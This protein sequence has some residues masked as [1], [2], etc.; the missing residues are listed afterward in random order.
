MK[1]GTK[2]IVIALVLL[3][4]ACGSSSSPTSSVTSAKSLPLLH[5][6]RGATPGIYDDQGRQVLLHGVNYGAL[7]DYYIDQPEYPAPVL[8]KASDFPQMAALG[9]NSVRLLLSWS[10]VEP[11]PGVYDET[12]LAQV[13][14]QI[15]KAAAQGLYV[16]VD[17]HQDA[18]GKF[19]A[20]RETSDV[21]LPPLLE[22]AIGWDGA[23]EWATITNGLTTCRIQQRELSPAVQAA[24][25]NFYLDTQGIQ[26]RFIAMWQHVV[27]AVAPYNNVVGYDL[28]NEPN[29]GFLV[30]ADAVTYLSV[31]YTRLITAIRATEAAQAKPVQHI[32]FFEPDIIWSLLGF[33]LPTLPIFTDDTN[34]VFSPHFYCGAGAPSTAAQCFSYAQS[35]SQLYQTTFWV[36]EWGY[37]G[38]PDTIGP[39]VYEFSAN[40][41]QMLVGAAEWQWAQACGDPHTIGKPGNKPGDTVVQLK[42]L[43]CPGDVDLGYVQANAMA[44]SR[45]YPRHAPGRLQQVSANIDSGELDMAGSGTGMLELWIPD[46]IGK[47]KISGNGLGAPVIKR[48]PGGFIARV[49]VSGAYSAQVLKGT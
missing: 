27:K 48:V 17:M 30:E 7:G 14:S 10:R 34:L 11:Q 36:G 46:R 31:F 2:G 47:P 37:F 24:F 18:W 1:V 45:A 35:V 22:D 3:L 39:D 20:T 38:A 32:I 42:L 43:G 40:Q 16:I 28:F 25:T 49:P 5:A 29:P 21:C 4:A 19:V 8:A 6:T 33:T 12:Y 26:T 15:E 23:P 9:I 13:R 44:M 41:D